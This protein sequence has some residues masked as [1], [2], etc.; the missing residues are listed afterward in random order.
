V[1]API[2]LRE[3]FAA[4]TL[5]R[6]ATGVKDANQ[7]RRL[8]ALAAVYEGMSREDAPRIGGM[9]RQTLRD[10][11]HRFNRVFGALAAGLLGA[12]GEVLM[13]IPKVER[14]SRP[15]SGQGTAGC[16]AWAICFAD[17]LRRHVGAGRERGTYRAAVYSLAA[18][19]WV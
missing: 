14:A 4:E 9:D 10:W 1:G 8:L 12:H 17:Q 3:D 7:A 2:D 16:G 13:R 5:R 6:M 15:A 11:V 18:P 19:G